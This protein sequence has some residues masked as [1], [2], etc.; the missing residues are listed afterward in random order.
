MSNIVLDYDEAQSLLGMLG[1]VSIEHLRYNS[2]L[3]SAMQKLM[4][5]RNDVAPYPGAVPFMVH[6]IGMPGKIELIKMVRNLTGWG[7]K[8]A[9]D[10][11][12][13]NASEYRGMHEVELEVRL[14][15]D[16]VRARVMA[17]GG[18]YE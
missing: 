6:K 17:A 15:K 13:T 8:A 10:F 3:N 16:E 9:K 7:L 14:T 2:T 18:E 11:V 1:N 12:D 4:G 5:Y